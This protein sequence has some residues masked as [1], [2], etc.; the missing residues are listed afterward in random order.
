M[1][2]AWKAA[3]IPNVRP[4]A[5]RSGT[6]SV[7]STT[8]AFSAE[9]GR[10]RIAGQCR[11]SMTNAQEQ[12]CQYLERHRQASRRRRPAPGWCPM[13]PA[14]AQRMKGDQLCAAAAAGAG[15]SGSMRPGKPAGKVLQRSFGGL[16]YSNES[17]GLARSRTWH[18]VRRFASSCAWVPSS[19]ILPSSS[20]RIRSSWA[21]VERRCAMA[22]TVLPS[23]MP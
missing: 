18:R 20:T 8:I 23:I 12:G 5:G 4:A 9:E 10:R 2:N 15:R 6:R 1:D 7:R 22:I 19:T 17:A 21:I 13:H 16:D 14:S 11:V 3:E